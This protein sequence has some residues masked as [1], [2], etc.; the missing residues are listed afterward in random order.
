MPPG[1]FDPWIDTE[2][3]IY[4]EYTAWNVQFGWG[5]HVTLVE[6]SACAPFPV[7]ESTWGRVKSMYR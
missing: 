4:G 6:P 5:F 7:Q 1:S 3:V 2:V